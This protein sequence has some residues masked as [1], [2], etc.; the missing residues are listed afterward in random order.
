MKSRVFYENIF[1]QKRYKPYENLS[2]DLLINLREQPLLWSKKFFR[3]RNEKERKK[4]IGTDLHLWAL[5]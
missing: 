4:G 1:S 2:Y 5:A 3:R